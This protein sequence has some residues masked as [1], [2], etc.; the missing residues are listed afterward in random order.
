MKSLIGLRIFIKD[1]KLFKKYI[2]HSRPVDWSLP[3][4][5]SHQHYLNVDNEK[6]YPKPLD[7]VRLP[8]LTYLMPKLFLDVINAFNKTSK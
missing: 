7:E 2:N 1:D 4:S 6:Y 8:L 3:V 5:L